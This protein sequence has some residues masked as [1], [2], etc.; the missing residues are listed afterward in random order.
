MT[1]DKFG[2]AR[3]GGRTVRAI[4]G[5][6]SIAISAGIAYSVVKRTGVRDVRAPAAVGAKRDDW[7]F[8][9]HRPGDA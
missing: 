1:T 4:I 3:S 2:N 5:I 8:P 7:I 9:L 6:G